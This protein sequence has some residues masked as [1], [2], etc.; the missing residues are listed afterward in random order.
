MP[1]GAMPINILLGTP[2]DIIT[3]LS[4]LGP[5]LVATSI[6]VQGSVTNTTSLGS[7]PAAPMA[8]TRAPRSSAIAST[9][10]AAAVVG[11]TLYNKPGGRTESP[12]LESKA[13]TSMLLFVL[14]AS[15][16]PITW[17]AD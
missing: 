5:D 13:I 10:A 15:T 2:S 11:A 12:G 3:S 9:P 6:A 4:K 17:L 14:S 1:A 8:P 16:R 7:T